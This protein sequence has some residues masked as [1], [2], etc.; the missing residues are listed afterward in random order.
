MQSLVEIDGSYGE[1]GGQVLRTALALSAITGRATRVYNIRAGRKNP[2]LAPQHLTGVLAAASICG[3]S[4]R[5]AEIGSTELLFSPGSARWPRRSS[6]EFDVTEAAGRGSAGSVTL[7]L[8][9]ILLP[10][11]LSGRAV[12]LRA[13]GRH[14][15]RVEPAVRLFLRCVPSHAV[16][17]GRRRGVLA[18]CVGVLSRRRRGS[19]GGS[20]GRRR[21]A[22][23][24]ARRGPTPRSRSRRDCALAAAL[25]PRRSQAEPRRSRR[26]FTSGRAVVANLSKDIADR[27][28]RRAGEILGE[29]GI[30][31]EV[32]SLRVGGKSTG[33]GVFLTARYARVA[34]RVQRTRQ[35][36]APRGA[37][38]A[39]RVPGVLRFSQDRRRGRRAS[40]RSARASHVARC[41]SFRDDGRARHLASDN[42]RARHPAVRPAAIEIVG[43]EGEPGNVVVDGTGLGEAIRVDR[44]A[45]FDSFDRIRAVSRRAKFSVIDLVLDACSFERRMRVLF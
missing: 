13:P 9:T 31:C 16:Q 42:E 3:A 14:A 21:I 20:P 8:Q 30:D 43:E 17:N 25:R 32:S 27:M 11:V 41:R 10:L 2:G 40:R 24:A 37:R 7:V 39:R 22:P 19:V 38:R 23:G 33:A 28:A 5:G 45:R 34:R 29:K 26:S 12:G 18:R 4:V 1:G 44:S 36:G 15:R 35:E 6:Y